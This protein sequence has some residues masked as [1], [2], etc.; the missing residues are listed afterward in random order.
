M[1]NAISDFFSIFSHM[2]STNRRKTLIKS[3]VVIGGCTALISVALAENNTHT[4]ERVQSSG[5]LRV[6]MWPDYLGISYRNPRTGL[7]Q[8]IDIDMSAALAKDLGVKLTYVPTTFAS[9]MD[10]LDAQEC[11]IAMMGAGVTEARKKR[12]DFSEP[13]LRSDIYFI[14]TKANQ[15][16]ESY[17][18]L[19]QAGIVIAVQKGTLMEPFLK[20][21]LKNASLA[22]VSG[23]G[24]RE[25]EV[26]SG[27]ADA[28]ATDYPYSQRMLQDTDWARLISPSTTINLT[29][30][31]YAVQKQNPEWLDFVNAFVRKVKAD[32]RLAMAAEKN[33]LAPILVKD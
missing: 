10:Q 13:Y 11:D 20:S 25:L 32:G 6:C 3:W 19:D 5:E 8:G 31:A 22:I 21:H 9:F 14:T 15:T 18:D 2:L 4:L 26:E 29:D 28:F 33:E 24:A 12:I 23:P 17:E 27:R 16:L 1:F 30:Y 7:L